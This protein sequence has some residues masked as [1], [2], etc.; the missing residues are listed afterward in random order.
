[1]FEVSF[2]LVL[3]CRGVSGSFNGRQVEGEV[4]DSKSLVQRALCGYLFVILLFLI[5]F[6][7]N[8]IM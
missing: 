6:I 4:D 5:M 3:C 1:M 8:V 2:S 7:F